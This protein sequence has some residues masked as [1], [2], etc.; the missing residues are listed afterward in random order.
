M[1]GKFLHVTRLHF[2]YVLINLTAAYQ[3]QRLISFVRVSC[4]YISR[5]HFAYVLIN[6]TAAY[7]L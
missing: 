5:L 3:L 1:T 2:A 7:Q 4:F 6:L